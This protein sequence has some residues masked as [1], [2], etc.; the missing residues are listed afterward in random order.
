MT[1]D[2]SIIREYREAIE[3]AY[4]MTL[5][6]SL[7]VKLEHFELERFVAQ[8]LP[9]ESQDAL[10]NRFSRYRLE[11]TAEVLKREVCHCL[12][13]YLQVAV[14]VRDQ[15]IAL[16]GQTILER[17]RLRLGLMQATVND[18]NQVVL[19]ALAARAETDAAKLDRYDSALQ[20]A[21]QQD[22]HLFDP[23]NR[24]SI[25]LTAVS[26]AELRLLQR[27]MEIPDSEIPPATRLWTERG[28]DYTKLWRK[29]KRQDWRGA[30]EE[31]LNLMRVN[32]S[33]CELDLGMV[34]VQRIPLM[35]LQTIDQLW[36]E[37]SNGRFGFRVQLKLWREVNPDPHQPA[38]TETFGKLVDW[39]RNSTWIDYEFI[40]FSLG[41]AKGHLPTFP[42]IG[43]WCW[44]RHKPLMDRVALFSGGK[45]IEPAPVEPQELIA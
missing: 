35:D 38:H 45:P 25:P 33:K 14:Y 43:W 34:D 3:Q 4:C 6:E 37:E 19:P 7:R 24:D 31:T 2:A 28:T 40:D 8:G 13:Y 44:A 32:G 23:H 27:W 42:L 21:I 18:I 29:L 26:Q 41:A 10:T 17:E 30:N 36:H 9:K 12:L 1:T 20:Q 16:V 11:E 22:C 15:K 5:V 39:R